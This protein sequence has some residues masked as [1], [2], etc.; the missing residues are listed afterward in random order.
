MHS[1][2]SNQSAGLP[3]CCQPKKQ[4]QMNSHFSKAFLYPTTS[5]AMQGKMMCAHPEQIR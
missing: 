1:H 3:C 2:T 5:P 4:G